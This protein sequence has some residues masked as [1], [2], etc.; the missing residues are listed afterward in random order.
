MFT[1]N[2]MSS[3]AYTMTYAASPTPVSLPTCRVVLQQSQQHPV[4]VFICRAY[5]GEFD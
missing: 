1:Y 5:L 2:Y 4:W 3:L